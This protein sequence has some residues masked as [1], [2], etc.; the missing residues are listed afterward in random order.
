MIRRL[1]VGLFKPEEIG[2]YL[3]DKVGYV[4]LY[5]LFLSAIVT[6]P[7]DRKSVV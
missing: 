5:I 6:I 4:L 1:N 2:K 7:T 3:K